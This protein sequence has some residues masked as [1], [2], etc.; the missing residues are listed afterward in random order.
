MALES[1]SIQCDCANGGAEALRLLSANQ[2]DLVLLDLQMPGMSGLEVLSE[3][4]A[5]GDLTKVIIV[6]AFIPGAAAVQAISLG[7][8][9]MVDKPMSL[10]FLRETVSLA[11]KK[12]PSNSLELAKFYAEKLRFEDASRI[13]A[14]KGR[15]DHPTAKSWFQIFHGL[16]AG[17][18]KSS[19][20]NLEDVSRHLIDYQC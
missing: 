1:D 19:M 16:A 7:V 9:T 15:A 6:S 18:G 4:R 13:L 5:L 10:Q 2:Y 17:A 3:M 20:K 14:T 8:T 11:L 12:T